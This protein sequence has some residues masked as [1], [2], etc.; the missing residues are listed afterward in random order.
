MNDESVLALA[1]GAGIAV[2]WRDYANR[3]HRV[4]LDTVR[5]LLAAL[6]LP[7]DSAEDF[8][9]SKRQ[10]VSPKLPPMLTATLG[11]PIDLPIHPA[12]LPATAKITAEDGTVMDSQVRPARNRQNRARLA[13]I[14]QA[15]YHLLELGDF[16]ATLAVAPRRCF[17]VADAVAD[18]LPWGL[19]VQTYALRSGGDCGIGDM[20]GVA[21]LARKAAACKADA[22][23]LSPVH[24]AF[25]ADPGWYGPYAPSSRLFYNPLY[26]DPRALFGE[27]RVHNAAADAGVEAAS[28]ALSQHPLIDWARSAATKMS[29][30]R[31]LFADFLASDLA[32]GAT[33]LAADFSAFC[34]AGGTPLQDH[35]RF[36]ALQAARASADAAAQSWRDWPAPWRNPRSDEV[37]S[38]AREH[39]H[40]VLFHCFLQWVAD[41]SLAAAQRATRHAGMRIGLIAD[42]AVGMSGGG[43]HAWTNQDD[44]L[45]DLEIG[46][47][48]DLYNQKGQNWGLTT[49]S[50]R[51]LRR[52]GFAP[53]IATLRAC[54]RHAGGLRIDHAMGL[55]RLWLIPRGADPR[56][57]AYLA[58]PLGDLLRLTALE[59]QRHRAL[60]IGEDLGTVPAG[61]RARLASA[62]MYGMR[63]LWFERR[64]GRF[65]A[66][67]DWPANAVAMTSTHD[68]PTVAGWWRGSDIE[69]RR[70][71]ELLADPAGE[72]AARENDR[73][74]LWRSLQRAGAASG[75]IPPPDETAP[76]VDAAARF[77]GRTP[78]PLALLPL[79]DAL[80]LEQQP[81]LPGTIDQ[82]PNW[83]RRYPGQA[84]KL[85]D[86]PQVRQRLAPLAQRGDR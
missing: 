14:E 24:A 15:G 17:S 54:L 31:L 79:E 4:S 67:Q 16:R 18:R 28:V 47:P 82:H 52:G 22:L 23:A 73:Q 41:R 37:A 68:L 74:L 13:G 63:V 62:G 38:F 29:V 43:S 86:P 36:E 8:S 5:H 12:K 27:A 48:P 32:T 40:E 30:L 34:A 35:A 2:A 10:F 66:P 20:A 9:R 39:H 84:D 59:S 49:F 85:L 50:P 57:G 7:C 45:A 44:I 60:V 42:L 83:R 46:A 71:F 58:Y 26:A 80:G 33:S 77:I 69:T 56:D 70:Q 6:G 3:P 1:R 51:A 75:E 76:V 21:A 72:V 11:E 25:A 64:R 61:F 81:N 19:A 65:I 53:F 55:M 78:S